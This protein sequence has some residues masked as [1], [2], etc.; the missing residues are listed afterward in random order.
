[1]GTPGRAGDQGAA[2][3][4]TEQRKSAVSGISEL[5]KLYVAMSNRAESAYEDA[6]EAWATGEKDL[7]RAA[8]IRLSRYTISCNRLA[9]EIR[10]ADPGF[11]F[12]RINEWLASQRP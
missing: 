9:A 3:N 7:E 2:C 11:P 10:V 12:M 8:M 4:A 5:V 1:M 6:R